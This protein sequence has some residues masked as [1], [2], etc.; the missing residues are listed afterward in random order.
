MLF[1]RPKI[2]GQRIDHDIISGQ[3]PFHEVGASQCSSLRPTCFRVLCGVLMLVYDDDGHQSD[4]VQYD[5][6]SRSTILVLSS[7]EG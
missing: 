3:Q 1:G 4:F 7:V 6:D 2:F 5:L